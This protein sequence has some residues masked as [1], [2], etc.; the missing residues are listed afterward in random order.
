MHRKIKIRVNSI[1]N[2]QRKKGLLK[3]ILNSPINE[4]LTQDLFT[5]IRMKL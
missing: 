2:K 1:V 3:I 4:S 5:Y